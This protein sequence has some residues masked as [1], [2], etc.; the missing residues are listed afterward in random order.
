MTTLLSQTAAHKP[1]I[2]YPSCDGEPLAETYVH[3]MAIVA[4]TVVLKHY[5]VNAIAALHCEL[6][7]A[8]T[9]LSQS[10]ELAEAEVDRLRE[11][12]RALDIDPD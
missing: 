10:K 2:V 8:H 12:L 3:L 7:E 4:I 9:A 11:K 5:L 6:A 1:P